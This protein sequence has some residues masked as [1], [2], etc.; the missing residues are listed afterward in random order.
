MNEI[1]FLLLPSGVRYTHTGMAFPS[2]LLTFALFW[3]YKLSTAKTFS[4]LNSAVASGVLSNRLTV[5]KKSGPS[6]VR[7]H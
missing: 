1:A 6:L 5:I 4:T 7:A 2:S 3:E